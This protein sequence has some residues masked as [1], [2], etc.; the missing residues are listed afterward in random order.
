MKQVVVT[1]S[2]T[3]GIDVANAGDRRHLVIFG[4]RVAVRHRSGDRGP[5]GKRFQRK[6]VA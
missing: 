4:R 2:I 6:S 5:H 3:F 1:R